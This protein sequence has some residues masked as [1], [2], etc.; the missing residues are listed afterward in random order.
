MIF[1]TLKLSKA[2]Q[3]EFTPA[4]A[5]ALTEAFST[6]A[7]D[8]VATK[9]DLIQVEAKLSAEIQNLRTELKG[10]IQALR[11]EFVSFKVEL[12]KWV[13]TAIAFNLLGT[14]GLIITL[15]RFAK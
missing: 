11:G 6:S 7:Q 2:L 13:V 9:R 8:T 3:S 12:I 4:H 14:A 5:E 10:D 1:D 15:V